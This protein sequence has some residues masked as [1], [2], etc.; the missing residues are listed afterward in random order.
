M[1]AADGAENNLAQLI[2]AAIRDAVYPLQQQM[3]NSQEQMRKS[4]QEI[5]QLKAQQQFQHD[6]QIEEIDLHNPEED[7][8]E[9]EF[10][11]FD[12]NQDHGADHGNDHIAD[13]HGRRGGRHERAYFAGRPRLRKPPCFDLH[14]GPKKFQRW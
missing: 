4:Q 10:L 6:G 9:E 3:I 2:R 1:A 11:G 12:N 8:S 7:T 13:Q 5:N 14:D